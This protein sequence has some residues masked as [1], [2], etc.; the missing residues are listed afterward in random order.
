[1]PTFYGATVENALLLGTAQYPSP[2]I[3]AD[4]VKAS[5][6]EIVTVSLRRESGDAQRGLSHSEGSG[7]YGKNGAR[8]IWHVMDKAGSDW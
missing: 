1:M 4:A 7:D 6:T 3:L 2:Q 5:G 8:G